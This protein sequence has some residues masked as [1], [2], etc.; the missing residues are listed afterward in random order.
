MW[1]ERTSFSLKG[2]WSRTLSNGMIRK[3]GKL[4]KQKY[5][6]DQKVKLDT[7]RRQ[8]QQTKLV[9]LTNWASGVSVQ[10][11]AVSGGLKTSSLWTGKEQCVPENH[12]LG[13]TGVSEVRGLSTGGWSGT[14]GHSPCAWCQL[15]GGQCLDLPQSRYACVFTSKPQAEPASK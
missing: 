1:K 6:P 12:L 15:L 5:K 3:R 2:I 4:N 7:M 11:N 8:S 14:A 13:G 10:A 9:S